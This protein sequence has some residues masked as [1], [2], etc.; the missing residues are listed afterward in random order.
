MLLDDDQVNQMSDLNEL[1]RYA[2]FLDT[3]EREI[4]AQLN[5]LVSTGSGGNDKI[6]HALATLDS[7]T[8]YN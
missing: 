6:R 1:K 4:D 3:Q 2:A 5:L 7:V 8:R